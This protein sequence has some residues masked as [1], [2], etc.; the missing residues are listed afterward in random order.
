MKAFHLVSSR[1]WD[2]TARYAFTLCSMLSKSGWNF[3]IF[4][5]GNP[6]ISEAMQKSE[7]Y[8]GKVGFGAFARNFSS[9]ILLAKEIDR[10]NDDVVLHA[11]NFEDAYLAQK[12]R[13]L[14]KNSKKVK[15]ICTIIDAKPAPDDKLHHLI[16]DEIDA[17]LFLWESD[18]DTYLSGSPSGKERISVIGCGVEIP[19]NHQFKNTP[20]KLFFA[21]EITPETHFDLLIKALGELK[22]LDWTLEV[23][24]EGRGNYVMPC[25]RIAR[26]RGINDRIN[27]RGEYNAEELIDAANIGVLPTPLRALD[28]MAR[29]MA[30][31]SSADNL[32]EDLRRIINDAELRKTMGE[33]AISTCKEKYDFATH[34][35]KILDIYNV[36]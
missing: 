30:V 23:C 35:K 16:A 26:D 5:D 11:Y 18:K 32:E 36:G 15:V 24:G 29:G 13:K 1:K 12:A 10:C 17:L 8:A 28:F 27:W 2:D 22:D 25:V 31:I 21:G 34:C 4:T 14:C 7:V 9:P 6:E 19:E 33:N 20:A 3:K